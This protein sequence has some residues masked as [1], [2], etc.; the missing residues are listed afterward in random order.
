MAINIPE[1]LNHVMPYLILQNADKF[2]EFVKTVFGAEEN[3]MHRNED[4]TIMHAQVKIGD[5]VLMFADSRQPWMPMPAGMFIYVANADES[6]RKALDAGGT[7]VM[8]LSNQDYGRTCGV[9]DPCG[10]TWWITSV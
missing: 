10:N 2:L 7:V 3:S 4:G 1:G 6:F 9:K 8:E 5:S